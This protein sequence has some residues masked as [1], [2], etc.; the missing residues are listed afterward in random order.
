MD[1]SIKGEVKYYVGQNRGNRRKH[2]KLMTIFLFFL[3][4][5][6]NNKKQNCFEGKEKCGLVQI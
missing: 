6:F 1:L 2:N 5:K 4:V 3:T